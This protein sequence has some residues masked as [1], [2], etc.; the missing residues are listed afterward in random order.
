MK[1]QLKKFIKDN[2]L[3]FKEGSR[4]QDSTIVAGYALHLQMNMTEAMQCIEEVCPNSSNYREEFIP[5]FEFANK[6][7]YGSWWAYEDNRKSFIL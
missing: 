5:V 4:N 7:G 6:K 2:N 1:E 3:T